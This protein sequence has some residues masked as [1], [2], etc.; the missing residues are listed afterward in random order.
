MWGEGGGA[1]WE[2]ARGVKQCQQVARCIGLSCR[3]GGVG[4]Q[5]GGMLAVCTTVGCRHEN[6]ALAVLMLARLV[7]RRHV[8]RPVSVYHRHNLT[9]GCGPL[10]LSLLTVSGGAGTPR[11]P[12]CACLQEFYETT[13]QALQKSRNDRL[14]FKTNLK[15]C[16]LWF[17]MAEWGR[18]AKTLKELHRWEGGGRPG[19]KWWKGVGRGRG[20]G[21]MVRWEPDRPGRELNRHGLGESG[22]EGERSGAGALTGAA[23]AHVLR[24]RGWWACCFIAQASLS[25][26]ISTHIPTTCLPPVS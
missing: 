3:A 13:L 26:R 1:G 23:P 15:L 11:Q 21:G 8:L 20:R 7:F 22:D 17:K 4:G 10:G 2:E 24:Q 25:A 12:W 9:A 5:Q 6:M 14:W 16:N 19:G 18:M